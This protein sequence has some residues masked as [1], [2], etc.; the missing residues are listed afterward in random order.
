[1]TATTFTDE[2]QYAIATRDGSLLL[3]AGAGSGKTS[4]VVERFVRLL[5]DDG[6][7]V[8]EILAITF[9]EKAAGELGERIRAALRGAQRTDLAHAAE[10]AWISTIH[11]F[12]A[13]I[14]RE[15]A[16]AAGLDPQFA[17][18]EP[19][20]ALQLRH[21][22]FAAAL[23]TAART[24]A[25]RELIAAYGPARLRRAIIGVFLTLRSQG[26]EQ[27][28]LPVVLAGP[29]GS[30]APGE[31]AVP[32]GPGGS[33]APGEVAVPVGPGES[34]APGEAA[35]IQD[36]I[37]AAGAA[38]RELAAVPKAA[39]RVT[40]AMALLE[41]V[42]DR[43]AGGVDWPGELDAIKLGTGAKALQS[44]TCERYRMAWTS[45]RGATLARLATGARDGLDALLRDFGERYAQ[46]KR[47]RSAVDF[48]DLE[49]R[50]L[51]LLRQPAIAAQYQQR[52]RA[53][54]VDEMQDTNAVQLEL[55]ELVAA[56][57]LFMVGDAQQSIYG[58][59]HADVELFRSHGRELAR[60][61]ASASLRTN[62]RSAP[63]LLEVVNR[64]FEGELGDEFMA[65]EAGRSGS[66]AE[67]RTPPPARPAC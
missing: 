32:V 38:L 58:F 28:R 48:E 23:R 12:C 45:L 59:R 25:G 16:L 9:T 62:F 1:V 36:L 7:T 49:L 14:L 2:Q 55:I 8:P 3:A 54:M 19:D 31:V 46:A 26:Q 43:L 35:A 66:E 64:C 27:P 21:D 50:A 65:L 29:G 30:S 53:V 51:A 44:E 56:D 52:F 41:T 15:H 37:A 20:A 22:A 39:K 13:R 6:L 47:D 63:E 11:G 5:L 33:S 4:V 40:A 34:S 17:V 42:P 24:D 18:L 10:S 67:P 61:G 57:H 60:R